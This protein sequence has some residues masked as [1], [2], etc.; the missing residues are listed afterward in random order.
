MRTSFPSEM[1]ESEALRIPSVNNLTISQI[2]DADREW[3]ARLFAESEPWRR[4]GTTIEKCREVCQDAGYL[5]FVASFAG[6]RCGAIVLQARGVAGSP[7]LKWVAVAPGQR[8]G[9]VG[10]KLIEFA[11]NFFR[12][13]ARH[14]FLCVS[15]F[16]P[17]AR[18]FYERLGYKQ[19]GQ[20]DDYIIPGAAEVLMHKR[21]A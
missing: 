2:T 15:S 1:G 16:N 5:I 18:T 11:E 4:L 13:Q 17:R 3:A 14:M 9:G 8:N 19:V 21:L 12:P 6:E 10:A 20:F 7:Y